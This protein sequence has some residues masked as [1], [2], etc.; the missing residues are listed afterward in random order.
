MVEDAADTQE[1]HSVNAGTLENV[2][3]IGPI[4]A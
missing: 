2:I 1:E 4:T 3:D